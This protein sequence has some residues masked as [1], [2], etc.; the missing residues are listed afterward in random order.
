MDHHQQHH[1]H[2]Q[3]E[4][5][6]RIEHEKERERESEKRSW[7][8]HPTWFVVLGIVLVLLVVLTW[9]LAT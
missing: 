6:K 4:R 3:K 9:F 5:E 1:Q 2:H 7:P 8:I